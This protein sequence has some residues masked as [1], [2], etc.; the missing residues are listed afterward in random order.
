MEFVVLPDVPESIAVASR[1][2]APERIDHA[3]GRPWIL[4]SWGP[5]EITAFHAG[6]RKLVAFGSTTADEARVVADLGRAGSLAALD[7]IASRLP[8]SIHLCAS[9]DGASRT[10]GSVSGARQV[11]SAEIDGLAVGASAVGPL[12][13]LAG[14]SRLD[15]AELASRLL[16][17]AGA[18]WPLFL[19][20]VVEGI[21]TLMT[22]YWLEIDATGKARQVRWWSPPEAT[23]SLAAGAEAV[24]AALDEALRARARSGGVISADLSGGMDSTIVCFLAAHAGADLVTYHVSPLDRAN[25]DTRWARRASTAL[26]S[27]R[28]RVIQ[29]ERAEN[30]FDA[31]LS[32]GAA[33]DPEGPG[34]WA[35]GMPH[36]RDLAGRAIAEGS[37]THLTG[38][39]GDEL[40]GR[41]PATPWSLIRV[42]RLASLPLVNRYRLANR[43]SAAATV[44]ELRD[45]RGFAE[46]LAALARQIDAPPAPLNEPD[47]S[48]AF[49]PRIPRWATKAAVELVRARLRAQA[50]ARPAPLDGDRTRHQALASLVYEGTIIRQINTALAGQPILWDAPFL[51][52][53]VVEAALAIRV[54]DRMA[55]GRFKPVLT[56]AAAGLVPADILS[57]SD[58]GE[59]SAEG[60]QGLA[61]NR[62][63]LLE[64]CEDSR[65]AELGLIDPAAFRAALLNPGAMS[66]DLQPIQ[67]TVAC[68]SWLRSPS[69]STSSE[70]G[71]T[72]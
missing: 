34:V 14:K 28:H 20:S 11:F 45:R 29:A 57:R 17:P 56:S 42:R 22:G 50:A 4:G 70:S 6:P 33:A 26:P 3:S 62:Q 36:I 53:R 43:W 60:F 49:A 8:G 51:D 18:P 59:F 68:E 19:N 2:A 23:L 31:D 39:G 65:L 64:L 38:F 54:Q 1:L 10:Q 55:G 9:V 41:M 44:R 61:R 40:F 30:F 46:H 35:G 63:R 27:A 16:A 48:W 47:F 15:E 52:D 72:T 21:R 66:Q 25:T 24:R 69:W 71:A 12:V 37:H 32:G 58:K 7:R 5:G 13:R 67:T